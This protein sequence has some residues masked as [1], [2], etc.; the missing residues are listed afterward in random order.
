M[1]LR[2]TAG[3]LEEEVTCTDPTVRAQ[4]QSEAMQSGLVMQHLGAF[5]LEL[6]RTMLTVLDSLPQHISSPNPIMVQGAYECILGGVL[7]YPYRGNASSPN[8]TSF[9]PVDIGA[10]PRHINVHIHTVQDGLML[11]QTKEKSGWLML[12][13]P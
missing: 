4:M 1:K 6:D 8:S 10:V 9:G 2:H 7:Q 5:L 13:T 11:E 12:N 3:R